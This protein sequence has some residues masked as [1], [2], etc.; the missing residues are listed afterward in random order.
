MT[1]PSVARRVEKDRFDNDVSLITLADGTRFRMVHH[2]PARHSRQHATIYAGR[3]KFVKVKYFIPDNDCMATSIDI[4]GYG[5]SWGD[6][7]PLGSASNPEGPDLKD[8]LEA[9]REDDFDAVIILVLTAIKSL[10]EIWEHREV[11]AKVA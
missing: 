10:D 2:K 1:T 6:G 3:G 5:M 11:P 8:Q 7:D 4:A 9:I